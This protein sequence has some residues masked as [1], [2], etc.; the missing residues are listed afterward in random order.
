MYNS[1]ALG[2]SVMLGNHHL[3][4][5]PNTFN[6]SVPTKQSCLFVHHHQ[7]PALSNYFSASCC[8]SVTKSYPTLCN[9]MD[10]VCQAPLSST[11]F[12]SLLKFMSIE[13]LILSISY[14]SISFTVTLFSSCPQSYPAS[15]SFPMS[16]Y[17]PSGGQ[18]FG[19]SAS[20]LPMNSQ[21]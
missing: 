14:I 20:V 12:W 15:E 17:C 5:V 16:Q 4:L 19:A 8:C 21:G 6:T 10:Y 18:S 2:T 9:P 3:H 7:L 1:V 11:I 13:S